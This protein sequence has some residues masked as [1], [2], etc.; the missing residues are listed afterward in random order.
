MNV[1]ERLQRAEEIIAAGL[2]EAGT[3]EILGL[4]GVTNFPL[5]TLN[6]ITVYSEYLPKATE[7]GFTD[8]QRYLHFLWDV[9]DRSPMC[10]N[11][12]FALPFRRLIAH[13][14][15]PRCG[16][17][18]VIEEGVRFNFG[19]GIE[20]GDNVLMNRG[21]FLDSKGGIELRNSAGLAEQVIIFTHGHSQSDHPT[22][23]YSKVTI[24]E[25]ALVYTGAMIMPGVT[26]GAE[27]IVA[28]RSVVTHDVEPGMLVAG[29]PAR[30]IRERDRDGKHGAELNHI[31]FRD[32][33]WQED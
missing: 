28:A 24:E 12:R 1:S 27:A 33:M 17:N 19:Q 29:M 16:K 6:E 13:A 3:A 18:L 11:A 21:C 10:I 14:L 5:E 23:T 2:D 25:Y 15:F 4:L 20:V 30:V 7:Y 8:N 22:R 26:V 31:W 32:G 9:F